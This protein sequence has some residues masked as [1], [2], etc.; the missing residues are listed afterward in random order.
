MKLSVCIVSY[1]E[2][3]DIRQAV[4]SVLHQQTDFD[5]EVV[6]GDDASTDG[7][8][9]VLADLAAQWPDRLRL[10]LPEHNHG[11]A[12]LTNFLTVL[13][14]CRGEY[15][16]LL[17]GDDYWTTDQKLHR[18][19]ELLDRHPECALSAHRVLHRWEDGHELQSPAPPQGSG[20]YGVGELLAENFAHKISVV[21][22]RS[23]IADHPEWLATTRLASVDWI[24]TVL[25]GRF[26]SI[27]FI[28]EVMAVHRQRSAGLIAHYGMVRLLRD[29]LLAYELLAPLFPEHQVDLKRGQRLVR[30]KLRL[31]RFGPR[32]Y[33]GIKRVATGGGRT[34]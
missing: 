20:I 27:A 11:D 3:D 30:R 24:F 6:V 29:R 17:D 13:D 21:V 31:A 34:C 15:V 8:R 22:R 1:Q 18:Q 10:I 7:T 33:E 14:A 28:D 32:V 5:F 12:G 23:A 4:E 19:V 9:T 25:A 26:G 16:A 2:V